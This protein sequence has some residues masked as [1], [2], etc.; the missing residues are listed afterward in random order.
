LNK[1]VDLDWYFSLCNF[2]QRAQFF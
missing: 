1:A 2:V